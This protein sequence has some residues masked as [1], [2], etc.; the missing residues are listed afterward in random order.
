M[1]ASKRPNTQGSSWGDIQ[2]TQHSAIV[3]V[4]PSHSTVSGELTLVELV[5]GQFI[6]SRDPQVGTEHHNA[7]TV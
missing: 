5:E 6:A 1:E 2:V 3:H 4:A 7:R